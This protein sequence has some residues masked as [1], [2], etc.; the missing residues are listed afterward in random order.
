MEPE[1]R[2]EAMKNLGEGDLRLAIDGKEKED[3]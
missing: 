1:R 3:E 2:V